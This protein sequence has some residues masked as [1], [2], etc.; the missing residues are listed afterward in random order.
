[1]LI[2]ASPRATYDLVTEA[3]YVR[4]V[5]EATAGTDV[6]VTVEPT[7]DGGAVVVSRRTLPAEL[8]S[9]AR[10]LVGERLR[11]TE[12]RAYGP[13][14]EA[15]TRSGTV[16]VRFDGAPVRIDGTLLLRASD[17]GSV[18]EVTAQVKAGVPL[19]GGKVERFAAEQVQAFLSKETDV[20]VA[21][22]R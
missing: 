14:D 13:A 8:P 19:V 20:A 17:D 2:P 4:A 16:E 10:A 15:G 3:A 12:T 6:E 1:M 5:A 18:V 22:L 7:P 9:Y 21:R 11:L